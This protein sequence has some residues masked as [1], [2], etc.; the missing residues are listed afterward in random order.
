[1]MIFHLICEVSYNIQMKTDK[2]LKEN[3]LRIHRRNEDRL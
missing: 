3:K 1:M 2:Y